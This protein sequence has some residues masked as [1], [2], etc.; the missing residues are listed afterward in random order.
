MDMMCA[1][2]AVSEGGRICQLV[3]EYLDVEPRGR[4]RVAKVG[5]ESTQRFEWEGLMICG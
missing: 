1:L 5:R 3:V 2:G 4:R